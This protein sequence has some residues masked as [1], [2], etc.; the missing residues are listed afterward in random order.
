VRFLHSR[1]YE[2][3][4]VVRWVAR[5]LIEEEIDWSVYRRRRSARSAPLQ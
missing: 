1:Y 5:E 2:S 4:T 3:D